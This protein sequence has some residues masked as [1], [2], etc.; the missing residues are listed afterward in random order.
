MAVEIADRQLDKAAEY[1]L[2]HLKDHFLTKPDHK[3]GQDI[4]KQGREDI[5]HDHQPAICKH[6]G[7]IDPARCD[8]DGVDG[9]PGQGG[10]HQREQIAG[11]RQEQRREHHPFM[12]IE[13]APEA[14]KHFF[15]ILWFF[16]N[17][18]RA[19]RQL[20]RLPSVTG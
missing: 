8:A 10:S 14:Q 6:H 16:G 1:I 7:K 15:A 12:T 13:I 19:L 9:V 20:R 5:K 18:P 2:T 3:Y 11:D 4:G 17:P